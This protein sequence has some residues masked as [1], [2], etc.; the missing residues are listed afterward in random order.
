MRGGGFMKGSAVALVILGLFVVLLAGGCYTVLRHPTGDS[1]VQGEAYYRSCGD[2]HEDAAYYHPFYSYGRSNDRWRG[3]YG[4]PW[5]YNDYWWYQHD[6]GNDDEVAPPVEQGTRHLW[7][8]GGWASGGWGFHKPANEPE[9]KNPQGTDEEKPS[10]EKPDE[11]KPKKE[12]ERN[13]WKD[14]KKGF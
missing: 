7:G 11:E 1:V 3:Y 2:C 13:L 8:S 12:D 10:G 5:W 9:V 6:H 4:N 14:K